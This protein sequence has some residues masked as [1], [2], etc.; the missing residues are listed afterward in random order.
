[1]FLCSDNFIGKHLFHL[2]AT[3]I[4]LFR[5][6]SYRFKVI[7]ILKLKQWLWAL[8]FSLF[9]EDHIY[10]YLP[11]FQLQ[12]WQQ[13][14][15]NLNDTTCDSNSSHIAVSQIYLKC[16]LHYKIWNINTQSSYNSIPLSLDH[17]VKWKCTAM[18][19]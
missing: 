6:N 2:Y 10:N 19:L 14:I 13:A 17:T 12:L 3:H 1:M 4:I 7:L 16:N 5:K 9:L 8:T 15:D 18:K 11:K